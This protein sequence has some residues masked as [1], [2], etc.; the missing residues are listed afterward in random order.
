MADPVNPKYFDKRTAERYL[1]SGEL[2]EKTWQSFLESLPDVSDKGVAVKT[3]MQDEDFE[4]ED[5]DE[6]FEDEDEGDDE[7]EDEGDDEEQGGEAPP[8]AE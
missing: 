7:D 3:V 5:E 6:D 1:R 8:T 2:D 4:D